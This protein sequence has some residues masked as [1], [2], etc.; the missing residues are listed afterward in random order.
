MNSRYGTD[1]RQG[2][3]FV[4]RQR[5]Q[6]R[7]TQKSK[8]GAN[9]KMTSDGSRRETNDAK[10]VRGGGTPVKQARAATIVSDG[11]KRAFRRNLLAWYD[12]H[13]RDLPWRAN[14]EPYRVWISEIMLQQ[15]RVV[16]VIA[17]FH[18]FL[19]RFPTVRK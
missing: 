8:W 13:A 1:A 12:A 19:R 6:W 9:C 3:Y 10:S 16:A 11:W 4:P 7:S 17:H 14:R 18:E 2:Y 5:G 15:T